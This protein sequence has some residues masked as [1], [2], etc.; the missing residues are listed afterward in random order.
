LLVR[1]Y[2]KC[3]PWLLPKPVTV[4]HAKQSGSFVDSHTETVAVHISSIN[5]SSQWN[6]KTRQSLCY[7]MGQAIFRLT[8]R[9]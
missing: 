3:E 5:K 4:W 6:M 2:I 9:I 1:Y 8:M 7:H